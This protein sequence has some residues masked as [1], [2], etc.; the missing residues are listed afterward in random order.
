MALRGRGLLT[1]GTRYKLFYVIGDA[2]SVKAKKE[3][4][5]A[6]IPIELHPADD[7]DRARLWEDFRVSAL[8]VLFSDRAGF[9]GLE[10]IRYLIEK[11]TGRG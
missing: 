7:K 6:G 3:L 8:P 10:A 5:D 4:R 2:D 1:E 9:A 11:K